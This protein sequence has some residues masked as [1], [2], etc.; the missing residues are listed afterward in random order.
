MQK[1][2]LGR[3]SEHAGCNASERR[4]GLEKH[5]AEAAPPLFREG[6][7]R[8]GTLVGLATNDRPVASAGVLAAACVQDERRSSTGR[9]VGGAHAPTGNSRGPAWAGRAAEWTGVPRKRSN[10]RG[11]KGP[12]FERDGRRRKGRWKL[13]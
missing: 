8:P 5:D 4:A 13:A 11:G 7:Q 6:C 9:P 12:Q 2:R 10:A 1:G 3:F